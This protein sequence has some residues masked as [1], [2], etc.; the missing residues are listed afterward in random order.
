M[1]NMINLL[2]YLPQQAQAEKQERRERRLNCI[3]NLIE[4]VV[5]LCIGAGFILM[6]LAFF[7][8]MA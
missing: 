5:T 8:T 1:N 3:A 7:G 4:S 6:L 2:P